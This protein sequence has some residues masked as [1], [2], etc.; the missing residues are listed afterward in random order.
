MDSGFCREASG[1]ISK[2]ADLLSLVLGKDE[3]F[4]TAC[5]CPPPTA[6]V[7]VAATSPMMVW[8]Y[9]STQM[10]IFPLKY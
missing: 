8:L 6:A 3:N 10:L 2:V 4:R 1:N 5:V 9:T 7:R